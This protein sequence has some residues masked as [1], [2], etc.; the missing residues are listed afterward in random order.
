MVF[1]HTDFY[2]THLV[3]AAL[4]TNEYSNINNCSSSVSEFILLG[5]SYTCEIQV[6]LFSIFSGTYILTL[7]GNLCIICAVRW[8][9][10]LQTPMYILLANFSFLEIWFITSIVPNMLAN[11]LSETSTISFYGCFLQSYFF[12]SMGATETFFLSA[13]AFDRYLAICRPLHYPTVM[14]VQRCIRIGAGCWVCGFLYF[15]LPMNLIFQL[16]FCCSKKI[17][18]FLCDPDILIKLSC[19]PAHATEIICAI[20][21]SVIIF[22]TFL[23]ITSTYILVIRAVLRVPSVEGQHKAF[24]TC[25]SHLAVVSLFYGSIMVI[26]VS[27]TAG[28]PAEIQKILSLSY[29]VLTPLFNPLI[30]SFR[31]KEMKVALRKLFRIKISRNSNRTIKWN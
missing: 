2:D 4:Q 18:H 20:Y 17:D 3:S 30:Y 7:T 31:N 1:N 6:F 9:H 13:M 23:F 26:Y 12:F 15:L 28:N 8:N 16:P 29:S 24:S 11:L 21:N 14:T 27:P 25:G 10:R 5:F 19:V 22:S